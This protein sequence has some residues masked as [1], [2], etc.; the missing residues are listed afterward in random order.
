M[1]NRILTGIIIG[2]TVLTTT[3]S[4]YAYSSQNTESMGQGNDIGKFNPNK[5]ALMET[6]DNADYQAW[7]DLTKESPR[8]EELLSVINEDNF[9]K[10][11]EAHKLR[12][13]GDMEGAKAIMEELGLP[14]MGKGNGAMK[15][16]NMQAVKEALENNDYNAWLI[17]M[18][19]SPKAEEIKAIIDESNFDQ[20]VKIHELMQAGDRDGAL[21]I[22]EE[23]G[24]SDLWPLGGK[25]QG[26]MM[27][28]GMKEIM[29]TIKN[30][31]YAAFV[32]LIQDK[33]MAD[34]VLAVVNEDN[35]YQLKQIQELT[36]AGNFEEAKAIADELGLDG[37]LFMRGNNKKH[38]KADLNT[39]VTNNTESELNA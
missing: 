1:N 10:L 22:V 38:G 35:F 33:P 11:V 37:K 17:V 8:A 31:D 23:L 24:L 39:E 26:G 29:D 36:Q 25:H 13:A 28:E 21:K 7:Y 30:G 12:E 2:G 27:R 5:E 4:A 32:N 9:S 20:I 19:G 14:E 16:E 18:E 15:N 6:F 3:L 34:D